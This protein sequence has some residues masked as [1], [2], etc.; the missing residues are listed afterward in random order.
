MAGGLGKETLPNVVELCCCLNSLSSRRY[1]VSTGNAADAQQS[2]GIMENKGN[3]FLEIQR[4]NNQGWHGTHGVLQ[5][6]KMCACDESCVF[7]VKCDV[8][9]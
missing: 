7:A 1:T 5:G 4:G 2:H 3:F 8:C 6:G 9:V